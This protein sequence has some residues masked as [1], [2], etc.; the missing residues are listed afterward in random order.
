M[1]NIIVSAVKAKPSTCI[2]GGRDVTVHVTAKSKRNMCTCSGQ[3]TLVRPPDPR[4]AHRWIPAGDDPSGWIEPELL[5]GLT[6]HFSDADL[7]KVLLML[8][9]VGEDCASAPENM[10][11]IEYFR[12]RVVQELPNESLP[13]T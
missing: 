5:L 3:I 6:E 8:A 2:D 11:S 12:S 7:Q 4:Q 1:R 9:G 10:H 13:K